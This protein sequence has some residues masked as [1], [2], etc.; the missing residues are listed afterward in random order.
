MYARPKF[1]LRPVMESLAATALIIGTSVVVIVDGVLLRNEVREN[2]LTEFLQAA[3]L[4]LACAA[5]AKAAHRS[6]KLSF[7]PI[8]LAGVCAC[9]VVRESDAHFDHIWHGFWR[10]PA[11]LVAGVTVY[12]LIRHRGI[13]RASLASYLSTRSFTFASIGFAVTLLF[14]RIFG[15]GRFWKALLPQESGIITKTIVQE[16]LELLGCTLI[17]VS[18]ASLL[19]DVAS[20]TA[21]GKDESDQRGTPPEPV[22]LPFPD[23]GEGED[24]GEYVAPRRRAA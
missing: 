20:Q 9:A 21:V 15:T 7:V 18:A 12:L 17:A 24:L 14:S 23:Q 5:F 16:G 22:I 4:L 8:L 10:V 3:L 13:W 1:D 2:S 19:A 6:P 11:V